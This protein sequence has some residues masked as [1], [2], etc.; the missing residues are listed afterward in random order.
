MKKTIKLAVADDQQLF[1]KGLVSLIDEFDDLSVVIEASNGKDLLE[2]LKVKT[3]DV[4]LLDFEM[5]EM[6]GI[7]ATDIIRKKYPGIKILIL[8]LHNE[9]EIILHLVEKGAHGFLLKDNPIDVVVDAIYAV[10]DNGYFFND[11]VSKAMVNGLVRNKQIRPNFVRADLSTREIEV[12]KLI[13]KE[14]TNKEIAEKLFIS[15]RTVDGHREKILYKT[16][17]RNVVGM[18]MYA[19]KHGLLD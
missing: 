6:D 3:P 16:K 5:P 11:R 15:V 4:I 9:E 8:T 7:E 14:H 2:K 13:C 17:A 18:V 19:M 12:L 10:I 1:R